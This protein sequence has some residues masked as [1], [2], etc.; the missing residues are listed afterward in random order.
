MADD[1]LAAIRA[2]RMAQL[3]GGSG[4]NS[5]HQQDAQEKQEEMRN[6]MLSQVNKINNHI[7]ENAE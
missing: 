3:Q 4:E 2:R 6:R 1:E 7:Q 5:S